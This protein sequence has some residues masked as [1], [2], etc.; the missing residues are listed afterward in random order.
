MCDDCHYNIS[1]QAIAPKHQ[2]VLVLP[3]PVSN[4]QFHCL[5]H[6]RVIWMMWDDVTAAG[7]D[8]SNLLK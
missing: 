7:V 2:E 8:L 1:S 5:I 4:I 6:C 3:R